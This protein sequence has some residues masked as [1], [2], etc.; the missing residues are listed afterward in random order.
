MAKII[1]LCGKICSGKSTYAASIKTDSTV[2]LSCDDL[3]LQ[4]FDECLGEAH[5]HV[6]VKCQKYLFNLSEQIAAAG[7]DVI[8]DFGFWS[9]AQRQE[10]KDRF[11]AKGIEVELHYIRVNNEVWLQQIDDRNKAALSGTA[12]RVYFVDDNMKRIFDEAFEEP[13]AEEIDILAGRRGG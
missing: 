12:G 10:A 4:L 6:L 9:R 1:L 13:T 2:I 5:S 8:L 3:M 7:T 11:H